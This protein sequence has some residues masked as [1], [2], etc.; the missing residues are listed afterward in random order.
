[1]LDRIAVGDVPSKHHI[2]LRSAEG[3]LRYEECITRDGFDGPYT[4]AYHLRRPHTAR[5]VE[6]SETFPIASEPL[7]RPLR[8]RHYDANRVASSGTSITA[9][10]PLL[11][12]RDVVLS[13]A[14]PTASDTRYFVNGDGDDLWFILE[15]GGTLRTQFGDLR[16]QKHDYVCVP[17][18]T[19]H[20][21]DLDAGVPQ[22][23][24]DMEC[25]GGLGLLK[26]WRN[27]VGQL[28]M[29]APYCHRD[30]TRPTFD[31]PKDEGLRDVIV[32]R[33]D[34]FDGFQ[35]DESPLDLVGWDGSVYP[36][37]FPILKFQPRVGLVHLP[38]TWHGTFAARG[39]LICSFVPRPVDF[40]PDA[41]PCPYP[42]S[43]VDVDEF[44]FYC[45]GNFTSRKG[46]GKG[47]ISHHPAGVPHGPHPGAYE[48]SIGSKATTELAVMLDCFEPL[49]PTKL[50]LESEDANYH[51][52]FR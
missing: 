5:A 49:V 26:Q 48:N 43:S 21:F 1:M 39:A 28:R 23:W 34:Q 46:I 32:K 2:A 50:A 44:I 31:G 8:R 35:Y 13:I 14:K 19:I 51:D 24:L 52:S 9:R 3:A 45:D 15:G 33:L 27:P 38:P 12:N 42:H 11:W 17:R 4:I 29:D 18:G 7:P 25:R 16:F 40:H 22:F 47:S 36:W 20:R 30:F 37:V 6:A 41:I 10:R